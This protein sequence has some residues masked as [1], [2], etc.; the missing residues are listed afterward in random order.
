MVMREELVELQTQMSFQEDTVAQLN[1][2]VTRQQRQIDELML[3][4]EQLKKQLE[5]MATEQSET[6]EEEAPP[7]HY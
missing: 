3:A 2:V 6:Q 7:P 1:D 5:S 4:I